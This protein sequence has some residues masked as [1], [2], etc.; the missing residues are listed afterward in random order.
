[1]CPEDLFL[2]PRPPGIDMSVLAGLRSVEIAPFLTWLVS[3][4]Q[5]LGLQ[6]QFIAKVRAEGA[7]VAFM[8]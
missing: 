7:S 6:L 3:R 8:V 1:M 5:H 2:V 4:Q